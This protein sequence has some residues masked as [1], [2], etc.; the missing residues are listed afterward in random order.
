MEIVVLG[1]TIECRVKAVN[2]LLV[3]R[4]HVDLFA[5]M[6]LHGIY[7]VMVGEVVEH[8]LDAVFHLVPGRNAVQPLGNGLLHCGDLV[9]DLGDVPLDGGDGL[10]QLL[11]VVLDEVAQ[12]SAEF[13][14]SVAALFT[15]LERY[16]TLTEDWLYSLQILQLR[17]SPDSR[18]CSWRS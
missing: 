1:N 18:C 14:R 17:E 7:V 8:S 6:F 2:D 3:G 5:K 15:E 12:I 13:I 16:F 10:Y 11:K 4:Y 9:Q